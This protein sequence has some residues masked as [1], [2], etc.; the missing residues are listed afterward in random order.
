MT[1][2]VRPIALV[3]LTACMVYPGATL[4]F[5][6]LYPFIAGE[7]FSLVG[8]L[9]VWHAW[10]AKLGLPFVTVEIAKAVLGL[11]WIAGVLGLWAG[12]SRAWPL[13]LAAAILTL[14]YPGGAMLMAVL[15]LV[16]LV[17]FRENPGE[18]PA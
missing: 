16:C 8:R 11:L 18:V 2:P 6:G 9:G 4:L 14:F 3:L 7:P 13:A 5:Q 15:A 12:V 17:G 1:R 10:A